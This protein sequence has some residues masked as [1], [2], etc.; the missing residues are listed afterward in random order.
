M[1]YS[2]LPVTHGLAEM[3]FPLRQKAKFHMINELPEELFN[4]IITCENPVVKPYKISNAFTYNWGKEDYRFWK[5]CGECAMCKKIKDSNYFYTG[6]PYNTQLDENK[7]RRS[8][9]EPK[10]MVMKAPNFDELDLKA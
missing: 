9:L 7:E 4:A 6:K 3:K 10:D 5:P 1:Y 8:K 2:F